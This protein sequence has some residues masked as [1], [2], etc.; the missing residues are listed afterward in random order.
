MAIQGSAVFLDIP[1][2]AAAAAAASTA[3]AA[4]E[5]QMFGAL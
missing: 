3:V 1:G 5:L 4:V 2:L